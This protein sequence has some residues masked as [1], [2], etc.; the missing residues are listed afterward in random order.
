MAMFKMNANVYT[1][2][3]K[4]SVLEDSADLKLPILHSPNIFL[5]VPLISFEQ[6]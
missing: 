5:I 6:A 3:S 2:W 4:S 1:E